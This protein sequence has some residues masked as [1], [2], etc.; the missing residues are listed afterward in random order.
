LQGFAYRG[1]VSWTLFAGAGLAAVFIV[2]CTISVQVI[3]V[4]LASPV[5][6]LRAE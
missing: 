4:A 1:G 5:E 2:L 3:R 6:R